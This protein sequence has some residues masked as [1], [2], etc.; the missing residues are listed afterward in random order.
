MGDCQV[1]I[2][3]PSLAPLLTGVNA[4]S[5]QCAHNKSSLLLLV[6]FRTGWF[7]LSCCILGFSR[8]PLEWRSQTHVPAGGWE[9]DKENRSAKCGVTGGLWSL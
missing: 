4:L 7:C 5:T 8:L 6:T 2:P 3:L 9:A 1:I